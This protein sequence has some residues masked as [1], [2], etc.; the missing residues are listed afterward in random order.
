MNCSCNT[1]KMCL[2]IDIFILLIA[3]IGINCSN[4]GI[5]PPFLQAN[6]SFND[7]VVCFEVINSCLIVTCP[8]SLWP[9]IDIIKGQPAGI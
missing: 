4:S 9:H 3:N 6:Y 7:S 5:S 2:R 8:P 1:Q